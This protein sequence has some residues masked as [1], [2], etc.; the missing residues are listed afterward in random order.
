MGKL[1]KPNEKD[2]EEHIKVARLG[3]KNEIRKTP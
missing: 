2:E 3:S 1:K